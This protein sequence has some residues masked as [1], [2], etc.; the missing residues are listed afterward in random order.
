MKKND[1]YN[2]R[3]QGLGNSLLLY[4]VRIAVYGGSAPPPPWWQARKKSQP[5]LK[6]KR[7]R[8]HGQSWRSRYRDL[9]QSNRSTALVFLATVQNNKS[10]ITTESRDPNTISVPK[11]NIKKW[12]QYLPEPASEQ[13]DELL[14]Q[15]K[16]KFGT[17]ELFRLSTPLKTNNE[18]ADE[19][20]T[21]KSLYLEGLEKPQITVIRTGPESKP[22][23][24]KEPK[25]ELNPDHLAGDLGQPNPDYSSINQSSVMPYNNQSS[26]ANLGREQEKELSK[27]IKK[28]PKTA[29]VKIREGQATFREQVLQIYDSKCCISDCAITEVLEAAHIYEW[30]ISKDN[31]P[32]NGICLR[33]DLHKL[34]DKGLVSISDSFVVSVDQSLEGSEYW[35]FNGCKISLPLQ[36]IDWPKKSNLRWR[37]KLNQSLGT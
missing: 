14:L 19:K 22:D 8:P 32:T 35:P 12:L 31:K 28:P 34:F 20:P 15:G 33:V 1:F 26:L 6:Q 23:L 37:L 4:L 3:L 10:K 27:K 30:S 21:I 11:F 9:I 17:Q 36:E 24:K 2:L 25:E 7:N 13:Y 18:I 5:R 16:N 29:T